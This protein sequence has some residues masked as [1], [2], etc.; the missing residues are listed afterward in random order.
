[1]LDAE[2]ALRQSADAFNCYFAETLPC[3]D[4]IVGQAMRYS[5]EGGGKRVR[6][7]L[8]AAFCELYGAPAQRV[9]P[10]AAALEMVHTY[11]LI[12]DDLPCMDDDDYRRGRLS[13]HRK[14]GEAAALLAGD[15]LLT[16]AFQLIAAAERYSAEMRCQAV[17]LLSQ[18]AGSEGMIGGQWL[19]LR[20]ER[21]R[22]TRPQLEEMNRKKTGALMAVACRFGCLAADADKAQTEAALRYADAVGLLFQV[23]DDILDA[24]GE[25]GKIGKTSGEGSTAEGSN[26]VSLLKLQNAKA[27][28]RELAARAEREIAPYANEDHLLSRLPGWLA[29]REY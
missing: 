28:A 1:M 29:E 17:T 2:I 9:Y 15:A 14:F 4:D 22:A 18:A 10:L 6:P 8:A 24:D 23:T 26:W 27:L 13:C 3:S 19:D 12:H 25:Q 7:A 20:Y 11:S 16:R 21:I 5:L